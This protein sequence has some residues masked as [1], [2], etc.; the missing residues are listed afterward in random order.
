[1]SINDIDLDDYGRVWYVTS[2]GLL[3]F[4][5]DGIVHYLG[6]KIATN[7]TIGT[8]VIHNGYL[9]LATHGDGI[10][11][12]KVSDNPLFKLLKD[13][14]KL[15][16]KYI[17][18]LG[19]DL[20][21]NLWVGTDSGVDQI[22]LSENNRITERTHFG[23]YDG[24]IEGRVM[25]NAFDI[26]ADGGV[27]FGTSDG[28][29]K[30]IPVG[31]KESIKV[32][33]LHFE[34]IEVAYKKLDSI[35]S[36]TLNLASIDNHLSFSFK[37]VDINHPNDIVYRWRMNTKEWSDWSKTNTVVFPDLNAGSYTFE[38]QSK[39]VNQKESKPV[40]FQFF[41]ETALVKSMWFRW[42]IGFI[43][44][45]LIGVFVWNYLQNLKRKNLAK[46]TKLKLENELLSLE[47]KALRLQMNP[48]FIFNVLNNIKALGTLDVQKRNVIIQKFASLMRATLHNSRQE[49]I[50]L[51]EEITTLTYYLELEKLM[52]LKEFNYSIN[53]E[54]TVATEE[55]I[56][57]PMLIQPFVENAIEHGIL[58]NT[59]KGIIKIEFKQQDNKLLCVIEDN[60]V[61]YEQSLKNKKG[62]SHQSVALEVTKERIQ[63]IFANSNFKIEELKNNDDTILGTRVSFRL[64]LITDY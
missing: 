17:Y 35:P 15:N 40:K 55:I 28:L 25:Q 12:A 16:S 23:K 63:M 64:P 3:G 11:V 10:W 46:Q 54:T 4:I 24:F 44:L 52:G 32:P 26:D 49:N 34:T 50:S 51:E 62:S 20:Q 22:K 57:P 47:Q 53:T 39:I 21:D 37:T 14:D 6:K 19:F 58:A 7:T 59:T 8:L 45:S 41:I 1:L 18:Q 36:T 38:A 33:I 48:H 2:R 29:V 60:G 56:L 30:Y 31:R 27:Y 42:L 9:Y 61:G 13:N 5:K 43:I